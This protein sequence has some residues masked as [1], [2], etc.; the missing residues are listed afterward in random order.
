MTEE[1]KVLE[2]IHALDGISPELMAEACKAFRFAFS[3]MEFGRPGE[4]RRTGAEE[5]QRKLEAL[6]GNEETEKIIQETYAQRKEDQKRWAADHDG[7]CHHWYDCESPRCP[8]YERSREAEEYE[9]QHPGEN[10]HGR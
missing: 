9:R 5:F 1:E 2:V 4:W 10:V 8:N 6:L 3:E 7:P